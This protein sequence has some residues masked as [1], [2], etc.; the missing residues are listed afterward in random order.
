MTQEERSSI[1]GRLV[2]IY[3]DKKIGAN[4]H[5][6]QWYGIILPL[7]QDNKLFARWS[8][9]YGCS[10]EYYEEIRTLNHMISW[11]EGV[12]MDWIEK[13]EILD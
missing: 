12:P 4:H 5:D 3:F 13:F 7:E 8:A 10:I 2:K 9:S 6:I 11:A 1:I